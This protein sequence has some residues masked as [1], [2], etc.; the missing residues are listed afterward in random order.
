MSKQAKKQAKRNRIGILATSDIHGFLD[1]IEEEV[2]AKNPD[3][4]VI[5]GDI[6]P[7]LI[8][9]NS[10]LWFENEF[11]PM[12]KRMKCDVVVTPGNHDFWLQ[13][14]CD[15]IEKFAPSNFHLLIDS[16]ETICGLRFYGTPWIPFISGKWCWE[17]FASNDNLYDYYNQMP[18]GIDVL[19][20]HSPPL[21]Q[22]SKMDVSLGRP[23]IQQRHF[24]SEALTRVIMDKKPNIVFCGHIHTGMHSLNVIDHEDGTTTYL[25]NV[26]RLNERYE[27]S[28]RC[29]YLEL[30]DGRVATYAAI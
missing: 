18:C 17:D 24:G 6:Q 11:F 23:V 2:T 20:S 12:V 27:V 14:H 30:Q 1:G 19:I 28:Y 4:F 15:K 16:E 3:I 10:E 9:V 21:L 29:K 5:A 25:Y 22:D 13:S 26:S 8:G 7:C